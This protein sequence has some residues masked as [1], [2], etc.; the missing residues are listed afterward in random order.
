MWLAAAETVD[1]S[2][3][4]PEIILP[5]IQ[6]VGDLRQKVLGLHRTHREMPR[7]AEIQPSSNGHRE[8]VGR[9]MASPIPPSA[10]IFAM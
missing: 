6:A 7:H 8:V 3:A 1:D 9:R 4:E 5:I 10:R 2:G